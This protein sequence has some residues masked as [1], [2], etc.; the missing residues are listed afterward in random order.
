MGHRGAGVLGEAPVR[1]YAKA[2]RHVPGEMNKLERA[3]SEELTGAGC[4][5][6]FEAITFKLARDTRY[7]PD[8]FAIFS[9]DVPTFWEVKGFMRDDARVKLKVVADKWPRFRFILV[10]RKGGVWH[11]EEIE[12][13]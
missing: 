8:F 2:R 5:W 4:D 1:R 10:T 9:D 3:W 6:Q 13:S 7:T 12:P 11:T